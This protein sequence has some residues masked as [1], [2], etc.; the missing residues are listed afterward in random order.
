MSS[1]SARHIDAV[2]DELEAAQ[3][4]CSELSFDALTTSELW[5]LLQRWEFVRGKLAAVKYEL[6]SPFVRHP[7]TDQQP[8]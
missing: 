2:F 8:T 5:A 7:D 3:R 6:T 1:T 4:R